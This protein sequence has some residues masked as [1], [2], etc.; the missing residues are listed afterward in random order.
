LVIFSAS[1]NE[2]KQKVVHLKELRKNMSASDSEQELDTSDVF[3]LAQKTHELE[4]IVRSLQTMEDPQMRY[5][6]PVLQ[7]GKHQLEFLPDGML[8]L[9]LGQNKNSLGLIKLPRINEVSLG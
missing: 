5:T 8:L 1:L 9:D 7:R 4:V 3:M 2:Y 6:L